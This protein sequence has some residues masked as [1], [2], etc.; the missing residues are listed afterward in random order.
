MDGREAALVWGKGWNSMGQGK[1]QK[2]APQGWLTARWTLRN[3][4][5]CEHRAVTR[6]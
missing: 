3:N 5:Q 1:Q 2:N 6:W 4:V